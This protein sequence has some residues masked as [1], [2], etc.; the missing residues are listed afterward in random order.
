MGGTGEAEEAAAPGRPRGCCPGSVGS[1]CGVGWIPPLLP[2]AFV[3]AGSTGAEQQRRLINRN[4][5]FAW[6]IHAKST[7]P[8]QCRGL[9]QGERGRGEQ[10]P[11]C[12]DAPRHRMLRFHGDGLLCAAGD[13]SQ[14]P[15]AGQDPTSI[16][17]LVGGVP[18]LSRAQ[19]WGSNPPKVVLPLTRSDSEV[20]PSHIQRWRS[21]SCFS[22][23]AQVK[24]QLP[25]GSRLHLPTCILP[26][27][28]PG[29]H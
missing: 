23:L 28:I 11:P 5:V 8:D 24:S 18:L 16:S 17:P 12:Q 26:R 13:P 1:A 6:I 4:T 29:I 9:A 19:E 22:P 3:S 15:M 10:N 27:G 25:W 7:F 21:S 14:H 2:P 20:S